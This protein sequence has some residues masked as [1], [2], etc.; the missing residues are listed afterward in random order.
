MVD[1]RQVLILVT[2]RTTGQVTDK[3]PDV[4]R[5]RRLAGGKTEVVFDSGLR[6][7]VYSP[8]R[9]QILDRSKCV[10]PA[11]GERV[12]VDRVIWES[13]TEVA[14]F[15]G[16]GG[17]GGRGWSRV[18]YPTKQG[19]VHCLLPAA[20]VRIV[21]SATRLPVSAEVIVYLRKVAASLPSDRP[22]RRVY[23][24]LDFVH[25]DSSLAR[26]AAG[27]P[28]APR[29][30]TGPV[31]YPFRCNLSQRDAVERALTSSVS[32]IEGPPGTGKT[33]TILN[34]LANLLAADA[35]TVAVVSNSNA[36][37]D[38]VAEKLD[39]LGFGHVVARLGSSERRQEF[40][41]G[42]GDR[43]VRVTEFVGT[44]PS[45]PT[46]KALAQ[47]GDRLR[48]LQDAER[49]QARLR[50]D[51][52]ALALE[53]RHFESHVADDELPDLRRLPLLRRSSD[54]ILDYLAETKLRGD[55][56]PGLVRRITKYL[57]YGSLRDL[58]PSDTATLL[59]L[60]RGFYQRRIAELT[61]RLDKV[62]GEL[63]KADFEGVA[64]EHRLL[65]GRALR[66]AL[67]ARYEALNRIGYQAQ[68]YR[69]AANFAAFSR[70]YPVLLSTCHSLRNSIPSGHLLDYLVIDEASMVDLLAAGAAMSCA[71]NLVVVGDLRQLAHI[72]GEVRQVVTA[73][74]PAFDYQRHS[75]LGSLVELSPEGLPRTLLR[76]HYRCDPAIIGFCNKAFYDGELV[77]F[78][79]VGGD[80]SMIV[81]AT[82]EGN[83][84]RRHHGGGRSNQREVDV[85][86]RE[87]IPEYCTGVPPADIGIT[88]PYRRQVDKITDA[89]I[90]EIEAIDADTVHKYQGRE[91]HTMIMTTVLDESWR[92]RKL[93]LS[94][95]DDPR[96]VNVAVSRAV[97]RF[98]LVTHHD[99]LPASRYLR[100]LIDYIRY[101]TPESEV[102][103]S[104]VISVFDLLYSEYSTRLESLA[105]RLRGE[106]RYRSE[107]IVWTVLHDL[108]AE[109]RYRHLLAIPQ[110][111]LR[112]LFTDPGR[113][114]PRQVTF[115][116]NRASV[117]FVVYNRVS[118]RS[119]L[120][121]EVDGFAHHENNP[122][123]L[124][125]DALKDEIFQALG[126]PLL[127]LPT[128][129]SEEEAK[130]R[131]ALDSAQALGTRAG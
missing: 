29:E 23:D 97:A 38:N 25:P 60:Q 72:P 75:I 73:P 21:S 63:R 18:F 5:Y 107:D 95:A 14:T 85:I 70:D 77:P 51:I 113:L 53:L 84:T 71:R 100:D 69:K 32:V 52:D 106:L 28:V 6:P 119:V 31:I 42:Q 19:E 30:F 93:D 50:N 66:A 116:R 40:F 131:A 82:V 122:A 110:V 59:G 12:E 4:V 101:R 34:I 90:D 81:R 112:N 1:L 22:I 15:A 123:Q 89:F 125:R 99:L 35:G 114:T 126:M 8:D 76:E 64:E 54:R 121:I 16:R 67:G 65:S 9:L 62:D 3:T 74:A 10:R 117:D 46:P 26:Y 98:I 17:R 58:D 105:G 118:N 103:G 130:I 86:V 7:Y 43:H 24:T 94:F 33:E 111:F 102:I 55:G 45:S 61:T 78:T 36:A 13:V 96:M 83:H 128:T 91:K 41:A 11:Q 108:L 27:E 49:E 109:E 2:D 104:E 80:E 48:R 20:S 57:R 120:A 127:R 115:I 88:T 92:S 129:G 47:V 39:G 124:E 79:R 37:V 44:A 68:S 56:R 87:V